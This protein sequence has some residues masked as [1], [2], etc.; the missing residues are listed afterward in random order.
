MTI[1]QSILNLPWIIKTKLYNA[2]Y[3]EKDIEIIELR[4]DLLSKDDEIKGNNE[5]ISELEAENEGLVERIRE[6]ELDVEKELERYWNNKRPKT[7]WRWRARPLFEKKDGDWRA[8]NISV[9]TRIFFTY[10]AKL[11]TFL[12][13]YDEIAT[14]ALDWVAKNTT[15]TPDKTGEFW[16]FA[17]ETYMRRKGDCEDGA[18][19]IANI[20]LMSGVPYWRIRLNAGNVKG[21]GHAWM[22][23]LGEDNEWYVLDWCYWYDE[24]KG[25]TKKWVDAEKYFSIWGSWNSKF[26][27][28]DLPKISIEK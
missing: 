5:Q 9:D 24:S 6:F 13:S 27:F 15:Y 20:M 4:Q 19:L 17:F 23:Y 1:L 8:T 18:I 14:Q 10:D 2:I 25:L 22:T 16:Q 26:M 21:G 28:G 12:G 7:Q 11:P 3:K